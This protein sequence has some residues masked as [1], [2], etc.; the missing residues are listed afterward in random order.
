MA[1]LLGFEMRRLQGRAMDSIQTTQGANLLQIILGA[2]VITMGVV[3]IQAE[4]GYW[5]IFYVLIIALSLVIG[6]ILFALYMD[7]Q[8]EEKANNALIICALA[9]NL[10]IWT[11][12]YQLVQPRLDSIRKMADDIAFSLPPEASVLVTEEDIHTISLPY[13]LERDLK[14]TYDSD[15]K[16][17]SS[18]FSAMICDFLKIE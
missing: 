15:V 9:F 13:Y 17:F 6:P 3:T 10:F 1:I 7:G 2:I 4:A 12:G 11:L 14:V 8:N 5:G 16:E 18:Q